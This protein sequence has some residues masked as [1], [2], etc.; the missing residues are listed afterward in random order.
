MCKGILVHYVL[1]SSLETYLKLWDKHGPTTA[2]DD[3]TGEEMVEYHKKLTN[4]SFNKD[5][6]F[7]M[8]PLP[9]I[10]KR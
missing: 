3:F 7:T 1:G 10:S 5:K 2:Q 8:D 9:Q 4:R 6:S